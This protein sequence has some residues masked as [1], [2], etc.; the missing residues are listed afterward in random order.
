MPIKN[1]AE[2]VM[3][4][5]HNLE[6]PDLENTGSHTSVAILLATYNG[7]AFLREQLASYEAQHYGNWYVWASDDG[8]TDRTLEILAEYQERWGKRMT[9]VAG[10][11]Q[12]FVANFLSLVCCPEINADYYAYSDQDDLWE[13]EK[14]TRAVAWLSMVPPSIP[15]LY[16]ARTRLVDEQGRD[17]GF[18]PLM[19][20]PPSFA[21]ALMQNIAGGN[22]MVFNA[23]ACALLRSVEPGVEVV[24]FDWWT[25]LVVTGCG[26]Q[27]HYDPIP[28]LRYR[29]HGQNLV[30]AS[31][32][33]SKRWA[34]LGFMWKRRYVLWT[35]IHARALQSL[36]PCLTLENALIL[37][38]FLWA[39]QQTLGKRLL[40][41]KRSGVYR[42]HLVGQLGLFLAALFNRI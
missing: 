26:G 6:D 42:Q 11:H 4:L 20:R 31:I 12:G 38:T 14:L 9:V 29:Q 3:S 16:C 28:T 39:R 13:P 2:A 35:D 34:R 19:R 7:G 33:W 40:G 18:S 24:T 17:R 23:A 27:V 36:G 10:P 1:L 15:A 41:L 8:S 32:S 21:N 37:R 22:T 30:G 25:Y 5:L